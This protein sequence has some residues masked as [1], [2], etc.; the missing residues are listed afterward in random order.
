MVLGA[1][2]ALALVG[3]L[4]LSS[5][6]LAAEPT[7]PTDVV[8]VDEATLEADLDTISNEEVAADDLP[9]GIIDSIVVTGTFDVDEGIIR[10][11]LT[12]EEGDTLTNRHVALSKR[13]LRQLGFLSGVAITFAPVEVTEETPAEGPVDPDAP[14]DAETPAHLVLTVNVT[15]GRSIYIF[16][17]G[18]I[19]SPYLIGATVGERNLFHSGKTG[20][21]RYN[22]TGSYLLEG[23]SYEDPQ[24]LGG[25]HRGSFSFNHLE[26]TNSLRTEIATKTGEAYRFDK[27][28][29]SFTY[30]VPAQDETVMSWGVEWDQVDAAAVSG[31]ILDDE[32]FLLSGAR[33]PDATLIYLRGRIGRDD[34]VGYPLTYGGSAWNVNVA[35]SLEALGSDETFGI[36]SASVTGYLP[37]DDRHDTLGARLSFSTTSGDVP[38]YEAPAVGGQ[39]RGYSGNAFRSESTL[40]LN[41]EARIMVL[42]NRAQLVLFGDIGKGFDSPSPN[43]DDWEYGYGIGVRVRTGQWLPVD[44]VVRADIGWGSEGHRIIVGIG[45]MF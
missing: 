24:F 41:T 29:L 4:A 10:R 26:Q 28:S 8:P 17:T 22:S 1:R 9:L 14:V 38:N 6:A 37:V 15:E 23:F 12:V 39:I 25:H 3:A 31:R 32:T 7:T 35:E 27:D 18:R 33:F 45:Q 44:Y 2:W 20:V 43:F 11:G 30:T 19:S 16:P 21:V 13:R 42:D 34:T 36:Y 5:A 40:V